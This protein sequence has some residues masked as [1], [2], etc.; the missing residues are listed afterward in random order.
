MLQIRTAK[1]VVGW[2]IGLA[3]AAL[4][5]AAWA[6]NLLQNDGLEAPFVK[7]GEWSSQGVTFN[8]EVANGWERFFVPA[9]TYDDGSKLRYFRASALQFLYHM[10]EKRDGEDAQLFWSTKP[11]DAGIYQQITGLTPGETYGVQAGILQVYGKTTR[12]AQNGKMF[13]S[14][15][16]D[17]TGGTDPAA[18]TVIWGPEESRTPNWFYPGVGAQAISSTMTVFVRVRSL[19][20]APTYEENSVWVDDAFMDIAPTTSLN[21]T[22]DSATQVTAN[23]SG[24]A[25]SGFHRFAYEAQYRQATA[26]AWTDLQIFSSTSSASTNAAKS[27]AVEPGV[28]YVVRARTWHEQDGGD[29]H[30]IPGPWVEKNIQTGGFI[31]GRVLNSQG[32]P[33]SGA[34]VSAPGI[35][36]SATTTGSG[37]FEL[38]TGAGGFEVTATAGNRA[39][40]PVW[41]TVPTVVDIVPITLTLRPPDDAITNGDFSAGLS[42][43]SVTGDSPVTTT[44]EYRSGGG[45]LALT[46]TGAASQTVTVAGMYRPVLSFWYKLVGDGGDTFSAQLTGATGESLALTA[47]G[48]TAAT[49]GDWQFISLPLNYTEIYTG[50]VWVSFNLTQ[51]GGL[52]D[53]VVYLDEVSLGKSWGGPIKT[54]LPLVIRN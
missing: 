16:L 10:T 34:V 12:P 53:T 44:A 23:W 27:F 35:S 24:A 45:S 40:T 25:R 22:V 54:F 42:G 8:L 2:F 30:E 33:V 20:D 41:V 15:G 6:G 36:A 51:T 31:T 37:A 49:P 46:G 19:Y 43:W 39:S 13:R 50:P 32:N 29:G 18:A 1:L 5:V 3:L 7:Y 11:F 47:G 14:L 26:S 52:S 4:P 17:P 38:N 9:G 21:L 48:F 28:E